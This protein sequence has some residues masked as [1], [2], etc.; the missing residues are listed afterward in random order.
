MRTQIIAIVLFFSLLSIH[1]VHGQCPP[2]GD[3]FLNSQEVV[4]QFIVDYGTCTTIEGNLFITSSAGPVTDLSGLTALETIKG[5][6]FI[7]C[8]VTNLNGF[9]SLLVVEEDLIIRGNGSLTEIRGFANLQNVAGEIRILE[10]NSLLE[11]DAFDSLQEVGTNI[12]VGINSLMTTLNGF[13]SL[14]TVGGRLDVSE[15]DRLTSLSDFPAL[16]STGNDLRIF[17]NDDL[18]LVDGF[19][20]LEIIGW[21]LNINSVTTV[22]GFENLRQ[23]T[24]F[25]YFDSVDEIP[26]FPSLTVMGAG[27]TFSNTRIKDISGF[28]NIEILG[29][30]TIPSAWLILLDNTELEQIS[31][32]NNVKTISGVVQIIDN[33][34][35]ENISGLSSL[36]KI[37]GLLQININPSLTSLSGLENLVNV[38]ETFTSVDTGL[39]I[40]NNTSLTD[41]SAICNLLVNGIVGGQIIIS[42]NPSEC[43]SESEIRA[44]CIPDFDQDGIEDADDLDDDNDGITDID[45]DRGVVDR[46]TDNDGSPDSRDFD[47]DNDGCN[48]V[49][50][51]GFTDD[52]G[53]GMLGDSPEQVDAN[54]LVI[55]TA[56]GYTTPSDSNANMIPDFQEN[57]LL[58]PGLDG[59][60]SICSDSPTIDLFNSL[61]G[62]PNAGGAWSPSLS[63]GTGV[64]NP[65]LDTGGV[66]TYTVD[67]GVCG[68]LS[69][70]VTV[71]LDQAPNSGTDGTVTICTNDSEINLF[72]VLG[73]SPDTGGSWSPS[74][75]SGTG[76]FNPDVDT[77]GTYT[78]TTSNGVCASASSEVEVTVLLSPNAGENGAITVCSSDAPIDLF[79]ELNGNPNSGGIWSPSLA[80]GNGIFDPTVDSSGVYT[81]TLT[82]SSCGMSSAEVIVQV[83]QRPSAGTD[84]VVGV[85]VNATPINL[86]DYLG[87]E[88]TVGGVWSPA[89]ESGTGVFDPNVDTA[90]I[91]QYTVGNGVCSAESA[92]V[93]VR[94]LQLPDAG[95]N[96]NLSIC[97]ESN[98]VDLFDLLGGT[99]DTDGVWFPALASGTS[100]FNPSLDAPGVYTYTVSNS[101]CGSVSSEVTVDVFTT[102]EINSFE[103]QTTDFE[104]NNQARILINEPGD[105]E[106][107]LDNITFQ[108]S[109]SFQNLEGGDYT[110]Y[111]RQINGCGRLQ[112]EFS[113]LQ[114]PRFFTPNGD[115]FN[116]QW[117]LKGTTTRAYT[118][119]IFNRFGKLIKVLNN[120][121]NYWTGLYNGRVMPSS[122]YWFVIQFEDGTQRKGNFALIRNN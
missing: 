58:S 79:L 66:Y 19:H 8:S 74:L 85:C 84:G 97:S 17:G 45:E 122:D 98:S 94:I 53:D 101:L 49:I 87:G 43:S 107:S 103:M 116:D 63:S 114:Y 68:I 30:I 50:E 14:E 9:N 41:C 4:D 61:Q 60:I 119:S 22:I 15:N 80:S 62:T 113:I 56:D 67:N 21:D 18:Q 99:P 33:E 26:E 115:G 39:S 12:W 76:I 106:Y 89:L 77:A 40:T 105:Y 48:D 65:N 38:A 29:S 104:E 36:E 96:G 75:S 27:I 44:G 83:D 73:G 16:T 111:V 78:Y 25:I 108:S 117:Q 24:R 1:N 46:D 93:D 109:N 42:G 64:F 37:G 72:D 70:N 59:A 5:D 54:G 120:S 112:H 20:Q 118:I 13:Q 6:L 28:N 95:E 121:D 86:F 52:D 35:L 91:F 23:I 32:F 34:K 51:A 55:A 81:Y 92:T 102:F 7:D 110:V 57:Q 2:D 3:V 90:G 31:G 88:P 82:S 11:V 71:T 69:A 100:L 47:S 10:N